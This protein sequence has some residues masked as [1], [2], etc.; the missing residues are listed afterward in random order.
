MIPVQRSTFFLSNL[1]SHVSSLSSNDKKIKML[2]FQC[3]REKHVIGW[4]KS[5][6][7]TKDAQDAYIECCDICI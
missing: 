2:K 1:G 7:K 3:Q 6:A 4:I 5:K